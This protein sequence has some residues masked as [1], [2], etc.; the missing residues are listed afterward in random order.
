[1]T[2]EGDDKVDVI[3]KKLLT[4]DSLESLMPYVNG[5]EKITSSF[6]TANTAKNN[7]F[8]HIKVLNDLFPKLNM[9]ETKFHKNNV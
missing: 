9:D 1:M 7:R 5:L 2:N 8:Y 3:R 6:H 4:I